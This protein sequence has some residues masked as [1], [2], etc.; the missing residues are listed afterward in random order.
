MNFSH[1]RSFQADLSAQQ[2]HDQSHCADYQHRPQ[3]RWRA[4]CC[5]FGSL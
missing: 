5:G 2:A 3:H 1:S 4:G